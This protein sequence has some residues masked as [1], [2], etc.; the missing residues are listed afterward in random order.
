MYT[1]NALYRIKTFYGNRTA[2]RSGVPLINRITE[3]LIILEHERATSA[4]LVA[5]MLHPMVQLDEDLKENHLLMAD[6]TGY[7]AALLMEYRSVANASLSDIAFKKPHGS[8]YEDVYDL[9]LL[10]PIRISP[11]A[12]VNK[13]LV[14]DKVQ[15]RKDFELYHKSTHPRSDEL[16]YYFDQ[17]LRALDLNESDYQTYAKRIS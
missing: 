12:E 15:N 10:R 13:M 11:M 14:A 16:T 9:V 6:M 3:G 17:W 1:S 7:E 5:F 8:P 2:E 4:A